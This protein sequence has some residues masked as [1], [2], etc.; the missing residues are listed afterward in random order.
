MQYLWCL[1]LCQALVL[2]FSRGADC[3][4]VITCVLRLILASF[5]VCTYTNQSVILTLFY[6]V[7]TNH[8]NS[9]SSF[10]N[11]RYG[12]TDKFKQRTQNIS[13]RF[14]RTLFYYSLLMFHPPKVVCYYKLEVLRPVPSLSLISLKCFLIIEGDRLGLVISSNSNENWNPKHGEPA[15]TV[16]SYRRSLTL[17]EIPFFNDLILRDLNSPLRSVFIIGLLCSWYHIVSKW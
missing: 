3:I 13:L 10:R 8:R 5:K 2:I 9:F 7:Y 6:E 12:W 4:L 17:S 1:I 14:V 11:E 15:W 16:R